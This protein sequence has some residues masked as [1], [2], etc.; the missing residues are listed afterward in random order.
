MMAACKS[1]EAFEMV[2]VAQSSTA[3]TTHRALLLNADYRPMGSPLL[4][5]DGEELVRRLLAETV[6]P[7][8]WSEV[9]ARSPS[10]EMRLPSVVA[11]TKYS[12]N[13]TPEDVPPCNLA[14]LYERENGRDAYKRR[15]KV[16]LK[17]RSPAQQASIDHIV[18]AFYGGEINWDNVALAAQ[19]WN[20]KRGHDQRKGKKGEGDRRLNVLVYTPTYGNLMAFKNARSP[21][22]AEWQEFLQPL[23]PKHGPAA[24]MWQ[25]HRAMDAYV[26]GLER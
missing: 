6:V 13:Q 5:L 26:A 10:F 18:P 7:V 15:R 19:D 4:T 1:N 8:K 9:W 2:G 12:P 23:T 25:E 20:S 3:F 17:G 11:L 22:P 14:N 21:E 16:S 24:E